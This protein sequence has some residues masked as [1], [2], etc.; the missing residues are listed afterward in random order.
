MEVRIV[1]KDK[2]WPRYKTPRWMI[3]NAES[4]VRVSPASFKTERAVRRF[5]A[6]HFSEIKIVEGGE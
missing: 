5:L 6:E 2:G 4:G 1:R 3:I